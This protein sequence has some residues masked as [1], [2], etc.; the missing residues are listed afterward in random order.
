MPTETHPST[1]LVDVG[2]IVDALHILQ[3]AKCTGLAGVII[4]ELDLQGIHLGPEFFLGTS[5]DAGDT[6]HGRKPRRQTYRPS[7]KVR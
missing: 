1:A 7:K 6:H 5:K 2:H 4:H 3:R